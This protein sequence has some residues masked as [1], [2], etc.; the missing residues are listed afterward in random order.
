MKPLILSLFCLLPTIGMTQSMYQ[1]TTPEGMKV[2]QRLPCAQGG[3]KVPIKALSNGKG[4]GIR[5]KARE[6]KKNMQYK[7]KQEQINSD[8]SSRK[9]PA[10]SE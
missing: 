10:S 5:A 3:Q 7:Q 8:M 6:L 2:L 4:S 9:R 1:C